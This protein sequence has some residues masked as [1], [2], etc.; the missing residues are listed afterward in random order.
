MGFICCFIFC[1][2]NQIL[3][4]HQYKEPMTYYHDTSKLTSNNFIYKMC[5]LDPEPQ[6]DTK[7]Y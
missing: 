6:C 3:Q 1:I 4:Y 7:M 5:R 2:I